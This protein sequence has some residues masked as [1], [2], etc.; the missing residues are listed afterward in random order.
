MGD[1]RRR[2]VGAGGG[3]GGEGRVPQEEVVCVGR[4][5]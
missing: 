2:M 4:G 5:K 1:Q 3:V